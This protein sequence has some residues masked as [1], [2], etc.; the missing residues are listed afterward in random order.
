MI[1]MELRSIKINDTGDK[2][3]INLAE[4]DGERRLPIVIGY[5]EAQAIDR[6]VKGRA[7][8]RPMTHDLLASIVGA[9]G[10]EVD[11]VAVTELD[12][13][14]VASFPHDL[15]DALASRLGDTDVE[16]RES[17]WKIVEKAYVERGA[18][19]AGSPE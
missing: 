14:D 2:Q 15:C 1:E 9:A 4:K 17:A 16:V 6:F 3:Y 7:M 19:Y 18:W 12:R 13:F 8:P 5:N 10:A 11:R